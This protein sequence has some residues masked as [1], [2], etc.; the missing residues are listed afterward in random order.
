[1]LKS[2]SSSKG[3]RDV[4]G[5]SNYKMQLIFVGII[6]VPNNTSVTNGLCGI[7]YSNIK[8]LIKISQVVHTWYYYGLYGIFSS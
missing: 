2:R 8:A 6:G 3:K 1:M 4:L 7:S 5:V